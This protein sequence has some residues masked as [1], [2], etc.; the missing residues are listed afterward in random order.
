MNPEQQPTQPT[1]PQ[2]VELDP[3]IP[4]H[5]IELIDQLLQPGVQLNR[6]VWAMA[7]VCVITLRKELTKS[8]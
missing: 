7:E 8:V 5:A 4:A 6:Q 2:K 3:R 1:Q